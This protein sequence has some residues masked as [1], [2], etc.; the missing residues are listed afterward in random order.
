MRTHNPDW[1]IIGTKPRA[2]QVPLDSL[3]LFNPV[4]AAV[5]AIPTRT[6]RGMVRGDDSVE[7]QYA[8][9]RQLP[10]RAQVSARLLAILDSE[11]PQ[12]A[13]ELETRDEF[14]GF[15][16]S[17]IRKRVSELYHAGELVKAGRRDGMAIWAVA[18]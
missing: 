7:S 11:G 18:P 13:R 5:A 1:D 17:S 2:K 14:A 4:E 9:V 16:P 3:D 15:A 8:A 6:L 12:T 10:T